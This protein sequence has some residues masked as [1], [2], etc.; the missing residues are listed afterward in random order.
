[1]PRDQPDF[2]LASLALGGFVLETWFVPRA[3]RRVL[4]Q[5]APGDYRLLRRPFVYACLVRRC[6]RAGWRPV[7]EQ[8]VPRLWP[9]E[10]AAR[11]VPAIE[12]SN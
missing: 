11:S 5:A 3:W 2:P 4:R 7:Q 12:Y 6:P 10:A 8:F 9:S 1:V